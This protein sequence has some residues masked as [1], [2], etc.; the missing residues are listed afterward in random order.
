MRDYLEF[1]MRQG[2]NPRRTALDIVGRMDRATGRR[3][4]GV[5]GLHSQDIQAVTRAT[6]ELVDGNP[7]YFA[8]VL[9]DRRYDRALAKAIRAGKGLDRETASKV[10]GRYADRL[11]YR[12]G[13]TIARTETI[14][15]AHAGA[16]EGMAQLIDTGAVDAQNVR[17]IWRATPDDRTRDSHRSLDAT[18]IGFDEEF[19]SPVTDKRMKH[20]GDSSLGAKGVDTINCRCWMEMRID[21]FANA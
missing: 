7:A 6:Q 3:I 10:A 19:V 18:S 9:R 11:L 8:R 15:S 17:K 2:W 13:E 12:R 21:F 14:A 1:G 5:V 20:P 4:G 16:N